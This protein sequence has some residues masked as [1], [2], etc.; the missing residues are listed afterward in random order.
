MQSMLVEN[1]AVTK[2]PLQYKEPFE[3]MK[4]QLEF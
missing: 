2:S 4:L 1:A 3:Q